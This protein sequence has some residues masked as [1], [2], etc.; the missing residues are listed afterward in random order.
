MLILRGAAEDTL[1][2]WGTPE[3]RATFDDFKNIKGDFE[4]A[5]K[6]TMHGLMKAAG[7]KPPSKDI[8]R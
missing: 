5:V 8:E 4:G 1:L 7:I 6:K 2:M 3:F